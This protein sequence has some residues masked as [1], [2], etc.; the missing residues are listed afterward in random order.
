MTTPPG[1]VPR[2]TPVSRNPNAATAGG[3][4]IVTVGF[5]WVLTNVWPKVDLSAEAGAGIAA[6]I[7]T[8]LL[9]LGRNGLAGV[10]RIIVRGDGKG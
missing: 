9:F 5:V 8:S 2:S 4:G 1:D 10:W 7:S 3:S 6:G